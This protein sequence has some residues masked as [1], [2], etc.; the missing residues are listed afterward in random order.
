[1]G[2]K[3]SRSSASVEVC[4]AVDQP[5]ICPSNVS[6]PGDGYPAIGGFKSD[7]D[8]AGIGVCA[9][10]CTSPCTRLICVRCVMHS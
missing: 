4:A 5:V 9:P 7:P 3:L 10:G 2:N 6:T 8:I 1:M